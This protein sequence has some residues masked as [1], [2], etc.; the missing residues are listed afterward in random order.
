MTGD[1][2]PG[3]IIRIAA[4]KARVAGR[5]AVSVGEIDGRRRRRT[6]VR[7]RQV[8]M[9]LAWKLT[10]YSLSVIGGA[11]GDRHHTTVIAAVRRVEGLL[12]DDEDISAAVRDLL[13]LPPTL[14][15]TPLSSRSTAAETPVPVAAADDGNDR[16]SRKARTCLGCGETFMSS[17]AGNRL[18][19][20]CSGRRKRFSRIKSPTQEGHAA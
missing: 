4:I 19:R 2:E 11:F 15:P 20:R 8:A 5:F 18:C 7:P 17:H 1:R 10:P 9:Y 13:L 3:E 6:I 16:N 14:S 12:G